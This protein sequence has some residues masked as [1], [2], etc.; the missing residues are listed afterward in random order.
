VVQT[1]NQTKGKIEVVLGLLCENMT[2]AFYVS[3]QETAKL[4]LTNHRTIEQIA[5]IRGLASSTIIHHLVMWYIATDDINPNDFVTRREQQYIL[6]A[7]AKAKNYQYLSEI[8]AHL[9]EQIT[10][11]KIKWVIAKIH[12]ISLR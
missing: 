11:E 4:Y 7:M 3:A 12:K 8:K 2:R 1:D 9:P 10:Y 6:V 5:K